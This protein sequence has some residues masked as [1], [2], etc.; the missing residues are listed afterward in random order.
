MYQQK[1][2]TCVSR[3]IHVKCENSI[4]HFLKVISKVKVSDR[5][6]EKRNDRQLAVNKDSGSIL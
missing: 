2:L 4:T 6:T 1:D 3:N 5:M